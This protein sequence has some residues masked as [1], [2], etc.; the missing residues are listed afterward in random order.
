MRWSCR[1]S[2]IAHETSGEQFA[3]PRIKN[4]CILSYTGIKCSGFFF[5]KQVSSQSSWE[6]NSPSRCIFTLFLC[7][8]SNISAVP[9]KFEAS[10]FHSSWS[11]A[12]LAG[13]SC[14]LKAFLVHTAQGAFKFFRDFAPGRT[15][16]DTSLGTT[17]IFA[18]S[19]AENTAYILY[20]ASSLPLFG[21]FAL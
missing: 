7:L 20:G 21:A 16:R 4:R 14:F 12:Y 15:G 11:C 5:P 3:Q 2:D 8:Q 9:D 10:S 1:H 13:T 18:V 17:L 6:F 19:P